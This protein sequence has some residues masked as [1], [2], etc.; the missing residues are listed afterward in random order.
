MLE[1]LPFFANSQLGELT[2]WGLIIASFFTSAF[3]AA[4]G[5]G[6]GVALLAILGMVIPVTTLIPLH[7]MVQ[8][9]SNAGRAWHLRP[10]INWRLIRLFLLGAIIGTMI[11]SQIVIALPDALLKIILALFVLAITWL[12]TPRLIASGNG[13]LGIGAV[14]ASIIGMFV[15]ATGPLIAALI[16]GRIGE[17]QGVVATHATAMTLSHGLKIIAFGFIGFVYTDWLGLICAMILSGYLGT[18]TGARLLHVMDEILFRK[19]FR[20]IITA[21]ALLM[22]FGGLNSFI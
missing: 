2:L 21:L 9:G 1:A 8:M 12:P 11:G 3:T 22:L 13:F 20:V 17:R 15:G 6:G 5:I 10:H 4:F 19:I 16:S 14:I 7:G 18:L